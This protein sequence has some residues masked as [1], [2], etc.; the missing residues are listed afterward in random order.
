MLVGD[1]TNNGSISEQENGWSIPSLASSN[2]CF[3][4]HYMR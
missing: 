1:V 3:V 4:S 2:E